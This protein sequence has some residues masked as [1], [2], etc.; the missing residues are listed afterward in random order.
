MGQQGQYHGEA[1]LLDLIDL[2]RV[3]RLYYTFK[4]ISQIYFY[5]MFGNFHALLR[6]QE[7]KTMKF[8]KK[9]KKNTRN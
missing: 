9:E 2:H 3:V 4:P 1:Q 6:T 7:N 5:I 8:Y